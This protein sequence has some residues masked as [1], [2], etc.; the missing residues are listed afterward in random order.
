MTPDMIERILAVID[1]AQQVATDL[2]EAVGDDGRTA[3]HL[4]ALTALY[5]DVEATR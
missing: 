4:A 3:A 5:A 1:D 2:I